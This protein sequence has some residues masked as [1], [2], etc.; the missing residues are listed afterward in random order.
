MDIIFL[1]RVIGEGLGFWLILGE[2]ERFFR[3]FNFIYG[4]RIRGFWWG[5]SLFVN[6]IWEL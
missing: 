4:S 2:L 5:G 1:W 6:V 3:G